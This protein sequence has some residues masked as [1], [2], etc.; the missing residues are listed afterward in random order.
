MRGQLFSVPKFGALAI[1]AICFAA[2]YAL[3]FSTISK[4]GFPQLYVSVL[5]FS[6]FLVPGLIVGVFAQSSPLMHGVI[7]GVLSAALIPIDSLLI[8]RVTDPICWSGILVESAKSIGGYWLLF[9]VVLC[10]P[11]VIA[12]GELR[13]KLT[14]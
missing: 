8:Q 5:F 12:G 13:R 1:G 11:G 6:M 14:S 2:F 3:F 4:P 7:L 10:P 9:G